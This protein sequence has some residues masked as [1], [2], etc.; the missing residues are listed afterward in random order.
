MRI[1]VISDTHGDCDAIKRAV[2]AVGAVDR[3]L[4]LGDFYKDSKLLAEYT[5]LSVDA[6]A[7]NCDGNYVQ[8]DTM[9]VQYEGACIY[10]THGHIYDVNSSL[11]GLVKAA[12]GVSADVALFGHT[13][14]PHMEKQGDLLVLNPGSASRPIGCKNPSVA[15]LT[16]DNGEVK[17]EIINF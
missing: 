6:V 9:D 14:K 2:A 10:M 7:G 11:A 8:P 16:I 1:G 15:V 13:H 12:M 5:N 4:H 3:W 17:A